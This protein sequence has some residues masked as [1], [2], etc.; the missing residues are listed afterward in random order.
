VLKLTLGL[1]LPA[2]IGCRTG[3]AGVENGSDRYGHLTQGCPGTA[4]G[5]RP[6]TDHLFWLAPGNKP[7]QGFI[8]G[9]K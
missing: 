8:T 7:P 1:F 9:M 4:G 5:K 2:A 6:D 3:W